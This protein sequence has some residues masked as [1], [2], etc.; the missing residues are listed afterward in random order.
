VSWSNL[1]VAHEIKSITTGTVDLLITPL[2]VSV[3]APPE[4]IKVVLAVEG[5]PWVKVSG[6]VTNL[7]VN[8]TLV[9]TGPN[10]DQIQVT[11]NAD[12][13]FEIPQALPGT[14]QIRPNALAS[15]LTTPSLASQLI[16]VV[17]PNQDTT[18]LVIS[19]PLTRAVPGIVV[20]TSG[21]GVQGRLSMNYSQTGPN[22]SSSGGR[23]F[24][25]QADGKFSLEVPEGSDLRLTLTA[26]GY[27]VKSATYGT[28]DLTRENM[29]VTAKDTA[30]LRVVLDTMSTTIGA[31]SGLISVIS[32]TTG[33]G[34]FSSAA[35]AAPSP[36]P[37]AASSSTLAINRIAEAIAKPNLVSSPSPAYPAL[38][39][40]A[41][42]QGAVVLQ[43]EISMEGR[44]QNVSVISGHPLLNDAAIQAVRQWTYKPFVLNG[45]TISVTTTATVNFTLP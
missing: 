7:G 18:N 14:Y 4:P 39:T 38:A 5:N 20:N 1:P 12:G 36:Q 27:T 29:R 19:L 9:L 34:S 43:V 3:D 33:T 41:R 24:E 44:V 23:T 30:E 13:T 28:T 22:G 31:S 26:P 10:V 40:A 16:S 8:R 21:A 32:G 17:I 37:Q 35:T 2:K 42:V 15:A 45:Q 11:V 6:R 25:T